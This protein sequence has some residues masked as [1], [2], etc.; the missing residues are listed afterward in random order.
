M[1]VL[2]RIRAVLGLHPGEGATVALAMAVAF[3]ASG[4]MMIAQSAIDALFFAR[5]GVDRLPILYVLVGVTMFATTAGV[6]RLFARLGRGRAF[7]FVF[8]VIAAAALLGRLA[9]VSGQGWVYAA[10]WLVYSVAEFIQ[11]L[12]VW[13]LAGLIADTRQAKRFFPVIGAGGVCGLIL[14]GAVTPTLAGTLGSENLL[15]VWSALAAGAGVLGLLLVRTRAPLAL[16]RPGRGRRRGG[17]MSAAFD[18]VRSS[19]LLRWMSVAGLLTSLLFSLLY[20]PFSAA[21]VDRYPNADD[22]AGFFGLFFA[23]AMGTALVVSLLVTGRLLARFG[24]PAVILVVPVLYLVAF[25]VLAFAA[26]FATLTFFRFAQVTWV[27]GGS[28]STWEAL[29]NTI[30]PERRDRVRAFLYGVAKQLGTITAG[31]VALAAQALD[32]PR[33]LYVAGLL[34]AAT[35]ILAMSRVRVAYP[36]ALVSALR[37]GRPTIFGSPGDPRP[38]YL[39]AD[40]TALSTLEELLHDDDPGIR[41]LAVQALGELELQGAETDLIRATDDDDPQVRATALRALAGLGSS[42]AGPAS[43]RAADPDPAVRLAALTVLA[44]LGVEPD[45]KMLEDDDTAVRALAAVLLHRASPS[46]DDALAALVR[47][48]DSQLRAAVMRAVA[49][50]GRP[51][52]EQLARAALRDPEW[53]V[54]AEAAKAVAATGGPAAVDPLVGALRDDDPRVRFAAAEALGTIG[55]PAVARVGQALDEDG[56]SGALDALWRLP[57]DGAREPVRRFAE[58]SVAE[59]LADHRLRS[60]L[61]PDDGAVTQTLRDSIGARAELRAIQALRAAALLGD[62]SAV[63]VALDSLAVTDSNQRANALEVIETLGEPAIVRP[64]LTLWEPQQPR[65]TEPEVFERL[66]ED[67]DDWIRACAAVAQAERKGEAMTHTLP[68]VPLVERVIFLRKVPL[69]AQLPPQDL[70]PIAAA[71]EEQVFSGGDVLAERSDPGDTMYVVVDGEVRV[72]GGGD[73]ELAVRGPG[74]VIGEMAVI[75]SHPR[76]ASL[77]A[78]TDVRVLGLHR[79]AFEAILRERP[80]T[81]LAVMRM[82]CERVAALNA[83]VA[84]DG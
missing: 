47:A 59:A 54:R 66:L 35:A 81:A 80:E 18:D 19:Q 62:R 45:E 17:G 74:D 3:L 67:P 15:V 71:A 79:P 52:T 84:P 60:A 43:A 65:S 61:D 55:E 76:V 41:R 26:V 63:S 2:R 33:I 82:L 83:A 58:G 14:G 20:L 21:A 31:G 56:A 72:L 37:E 57:L 8:A 30:P 10:L 27:S 40:S 42:A 48:E 11:V 77:V 7:L 44:D 51:D 22:L 73:Q 25:G 46:A 39:H 69:F 4:G 34:G 64:L 50:A 16:A 38:V 1:S 24:V 75:S 28:S 9:I 78:K 53:P 12:A 49:T 36:R 13:G 23:A 32:E 29:V 68:T 5:Y 6:G 70:Q